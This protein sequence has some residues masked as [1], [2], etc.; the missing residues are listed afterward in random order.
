MTRYLLYARKSQEDEGRQQQSIADQV[1]VMLDSASRLGLHLV[2]TFTEEKSA[3]EPYQRPVFD[4]VIRMIEKGEAEALIC[5]NVNRLARNMVEGGLL[6]HLLT[7]GKLKE[8]R[9]YNEVFKSGDNILPFI[10][11]TAMSTQYSLDLSQIVKRGLKSKVEKGLYPQ[12]A[13]EGYMNNLYERTI[14]RD[15]E[16]FVLIRKAW[17]LMLTGSY[18]VEKLAGVM[19]K[20]WGYRTRQTRKQGGSPMS[21]TCLHRIF[22]NVFY[23][24]MFMY[25][26]ELIQGKH[27]PMITMQEYEAVQ[28][29]LRRPG[30]TKRQRR[31][32]PYTGFIVCAACGR[33]VTAEYQKGRHKRGDYTYYH[34]VNAAKCGSGYVS[35]EDLEREIATY[36]NSVKVNPEIRPICIDTIERMFTEASNEE[37]AQLAQQ[38]RALE[39]AQQQMSKLI[40]MSIKDMISEEDFEK[41][42]LDLQTQ[43]NAL[44]SDANK[45]ERKLEEVRL[46]ALEVAEFVTTA[47]IK[48]MFGETHHKREI[49]KK[50]GVM[51][52]LGNGKLEMNLNPLLVP[53]YNSASEPRK[54]GSGSNKKG[55]F[56][57]A[58]PV[59]GHTGMMF[60]PLQKVWNLLMDG[61]PKLGAH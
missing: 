41:E 15:A 22:C 26:G 49:A 52:R 44:R 9:T 37:Q 27:E 13:P 14:D 25:N 58:M 55:T 16:R 6:Q 34:C 4:K 56:V 7:K 30:H 39:E 24:G 61:A 31:D 29:A 57:P 2:N 28:K 59:G 43:I 3:K 21:R 11:Q 20:E 38:N 32:F 33:Q 12:R 8:I 46:G 50:L 17:D 23:T 36:L 48:F 18:S 45:A 1:S 10:L 47:P 5:Y 54:I 51:Y 35:Q 42:K 40:K 19:S 60:E 53:F